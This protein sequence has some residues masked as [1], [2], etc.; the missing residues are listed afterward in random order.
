MQ[1][2]VENG[3]EAIHWLIDQGVQFSKE[4]DGETYHLTKEGGH[5]NRRI[6]HAADATGMEVAKT[7]T[8]LTEEHPNITLL[9]DYI[10]VDLV[11]NKQSQ[12]RKCSGAYLLNLKTNEVELFSAK[13]TV[14]ATG[15]ASKVYLYTSNPDGNSGDGIAMAWRAGCRVANMEFN[16]FHPTCLYLSL[17]H[18]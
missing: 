15:G 10:A 9:E 5:G 8:Q 14:L 1:F 13:A 3:K 11:V 2:I 4:K 12:P 16:Q 6:I 18:I 7:L 17:I